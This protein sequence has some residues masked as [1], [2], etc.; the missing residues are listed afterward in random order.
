MSEVRLSANRRVAFLMAEKSYHLSFIGLAGKIA[1]SSK[2]PLFSCLNDGYTCIDQKYAVPV[3]RAADQAVAGKGRLYLTESSKEEAIVRGSGTN[4][5]KQ[6]VPK[7]QIQ[8][9]KSYGSDIVE[10]IKVI[11]DE[12]VK[13]KKIFAKESAVKDLLAAGEK[14]KR[15]EDGAGLKYKCLPYIDQAKVSC[16][17]IPPMR[18]LFSAEFD[19][20]G[21]CTP[22]CTRSCR[23]ADV[24]VYSQKEVLTTGRTF[25]HYALDWQLWH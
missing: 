15:G 11:D 3:A 24:S 1:H 5:L 4:F 12:S 13:V 21:R 19:V 14:K 10:V 8:L 9:E 2:K 23:T 25:S 6:L 17:V 16:M 22:P 7:G 20:C 18:Q